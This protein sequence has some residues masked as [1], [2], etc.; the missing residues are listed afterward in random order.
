[1]GAIVGLLA[2]LVGLI[3]GVI[4]LVGALRSDPPPRR[5]AEL[6]ELD[7]VPDLSFRQL[8]RRKDQ[9]LDGYP[10]AAL[11]RRG[12]YVEFR[13]SIT[14]YRDEQLALKQTLYDAET[15][16][17]I[18][19]DEATLLEPVSDED[20]GTLDAFVEHPARPGRYYVLLQLYEPRGVVPLARLQ[21]DRFRV[22]D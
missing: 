17:E 1:M 15:R 14:G 7:F 16:E 3:T 5:A 2:T 20:E 12:A 6:G 8:L 10:E 18:S 4:S 11:D 9:P 22:R 19:E 21:T 13:F